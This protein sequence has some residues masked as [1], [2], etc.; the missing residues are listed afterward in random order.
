M[1][2]HLGSDHAG[3]RLKEHVKSR[4]ATAGHSVIDVGTDSEDSTD[5]PIFAGKV[6]RAVSAGEAEM[7][8]LVCGTGI[9]MAMAANKV[10]GV[11]AANVVDDP[12]LARLARQHNDAN[13]LTLGG[14]FTSET[15]ADAIVDAFLETPFEGGRHERRVDEI[16]DIEDEY[17]PAGRGTPSGS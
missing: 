11:R 16:G 13:V 15:A 2:I 7:G 10:R 5:Y 3:F 6:A 14:R 12:E 17:R 9:G 4:L 8:I 1:R